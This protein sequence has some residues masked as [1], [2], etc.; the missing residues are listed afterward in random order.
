MLRRK[1]S[2]VIVIIIVVMG[3]G[4]II[5]AVITMLMNNYELCGSANLFSGYT[6]ELDNG[7]K[8]DMEEFIPLAVMKQMEKS[9]E[10][11]RYGK[12]SDEAVKAQIVINRT[13][14]MK[15]MNNGTVKLSDINMEYESE[16]CI[17]KKKGTAYK[18]YV[19]IHNLSA[20]T[21]YNIM[22][23][24]NKPINAYYHSISAGKTRNGKEEYIISADS[25][26]DIR[27]EQYL[28]ITYYTPQ[29]LNDIIKNEF[30]IDIGTDN[31]VDKIHL[32]A[33]QSTG[34]VEE[35]IIQD[36]SNVFSGD[37]FCRKMNIK[38]PCF[39]IEKYNEA[40]RIISKGVGNGR[41]L[42]MYGAV[43]MA[44][45]GCGYKEILLHYYKGIKFQNIKKYN[46]VSTSSVVNN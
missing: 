27:A 28:N 16:K 2:S 46:K 40:I 23:Y 41:G 30:G 44:N 25:V 39:V 42:S 45:A 21:K 19:K 36:E 26:D 1:C 22:T 5:P 20:R 17:K 4:M 43:Q 11:S 24:D 33:Q 37:D 14:L 35:V 18:E 6:V 9:G 32:T 8:M 3:G 10:N 15:N 12:K 38:S 13:R 34:Y 31:Q 7:K 29:E